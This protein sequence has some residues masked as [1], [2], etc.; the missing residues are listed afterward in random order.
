M[1]LRV[2]N[3]SH[4]IRYVI[5][6]KEKYLVELPLQKGCEYQGISRMDQGKSQDFLGGVYDTFCK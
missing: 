1:V 3:A 5:H 4:C 6:N 2:D